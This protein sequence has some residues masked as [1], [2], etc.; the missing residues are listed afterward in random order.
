MI[1][2]RTISQQNKLRSVTQKIALQINCKLGGELWA[3]DV[4][5]VKCHVFPFRS[6]ILYFQKL[7]PNVLFTTSFLFTEKFDGCWH[8]CV[9]WHQPR[10]PFCWWFRSKH[11][12]FTDSLVLASVLPNT[13]TRTGQWVEDVFDVSSEE[14]PRGKHVITLGLRWDPS[15][16]FLSNSKLLQSELVPQLCCEPL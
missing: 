6:V 14:V 11:Q 4:P 12:S 15:E 5:L 10:W 3:L 7:L 9:P 2:A 1:N 8:W 16:S 13:R